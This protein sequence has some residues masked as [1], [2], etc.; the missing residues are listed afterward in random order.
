MEIQQVN[1]AAWE[2]EILGRFWL[3]CA[4]RKTLAKPKPIANSNVF[5]S[6]TQD[7]TYCGRIPQSRSGQQLEF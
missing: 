6:L 7:D 2:G 1:E 3:R 5:S 4:A